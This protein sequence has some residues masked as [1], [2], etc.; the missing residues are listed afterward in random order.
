MEFLRSLKIKNP[1]KQYFS[2]HE[3]AKQ[4]GRC[5]RRKKDVK[6]MKLTEKNTIH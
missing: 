5:D 4:T 3:H 2:K 6:F 1:M